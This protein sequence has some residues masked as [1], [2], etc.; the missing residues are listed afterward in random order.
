[1]EYMAEHRIEGKDGSKGEK[2]ADES[3]KASRSVSNARTGDGDV[4]MTT[5][6][7]LQDPNFPSHPPNSP[8]NWFPDVT[9]PPYVPASPG[10]GEPG[11]PYRPSS[12]TSSEFDSIRERISLLE[13]RVEESNTELKE[14][15]RQLETQMFEDGCTLTEVKWQQAELKKVENKIKA[16]RKKTNRRSAPNPPT[17]RYP[18]RSTTWVTDEKWMEVRNDLAAAKNRI[19]GL[20]DRME[21]ARQEIERL[22]SKIDQVLALAPR[23]EELGERVDRNRKEQNDMNSIIL[24]EIAT[25]QN[26][27][28]PN[29][30]TQIKQ[31]AFEIANLTTLYHQINQVASSLLYPTQDTG[32]DYRN[33][34]SRSN[35]SVENTPERRIVHAF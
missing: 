15:L 14:R 6:L 17:H 3:A 1:M 26:K 16:N 22:K 8:V 28:T 25:L 2:K 10:P 30:A 5:H 7:E 20:E 27:T 12:P 18:T 9:V 35:F 4:E 19:Q 13:D 23:L 29:L 31:Q 34:Y 24:S 32:Y 21:S 33:N 11:T